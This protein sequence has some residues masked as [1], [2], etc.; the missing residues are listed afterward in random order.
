MPGSCSVRTGASMPRE[1]PDTAEQASEFGATGFDDR[2]HGCFRMLFLYDVAEAI[3]LDQLKQLLGPRGDVQEPRF[4]R[5]TPEHIRFEVPPYIER[6]EPVHLPT[7]QI[8][9]CSLRYYAFAVI[10]LQLELPFEGDWHELVR[11]AARWSGSAE[12]EGEMR[13][14]VREHVDRAA[15]A[16]ARLHKQWLH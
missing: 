13:A 9:S 15:G 14:L 12:L 5:G 3:D 1:H 4:G 7:G 6:A 8:A 11:E 16:I 10:A 2:L